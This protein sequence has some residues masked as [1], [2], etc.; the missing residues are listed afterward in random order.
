MISTSPGSKIKGMVWLAIALAMGAAFALGMPFIARH[1]PWSIEKRLARV[2]NGLP[3]IQACDR[4]THK[5]AA[6][7]FDKAVQLLDP[8]IHRRV[9]QSN[10]PPLEL[11]RKF[12]HL[13]IRVVLQEVDVSGDEVP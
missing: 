2:P 8:I 9:E 10:F 12:R 3:D 4:N 7:L 11:S 1:I 5:E 13:I 6:A